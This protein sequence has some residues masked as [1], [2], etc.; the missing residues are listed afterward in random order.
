MLPFSRREHHTT[1]APEWCS[2]AQRDT[3]GWAP[4]LQR[5]EELTNG[6]MPHLPAR[7]NKLYT[8]YFIFFN[9][10]KSKAPHQIRIVY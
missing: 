1:S 7:V 2:R 5:A 8:A 6:V 9:G 10:Y 4:P 3:T